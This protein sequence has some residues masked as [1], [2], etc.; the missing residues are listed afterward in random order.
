MINQHKIKNFWD[1]RAD[2]VKDLTFESIVNLEEDPKNLQ[3]KIDLET[4]K[5]FDWLPDL[6]GKTILDL[7]AGVGQWSFRFIERG[8]KHV[9][10]VEYSAPLAEIGRQVAIDRN[11]NNID[12]VVSGAEQFK[13]EEKFDVVFISGLFVYLVEDQARELMSNLPGFCH[14]DTFVL[15]RDGTAIDQHYEIND[16]HSAHLNTAYS[17]IYR[18]RE[19][20]ISLFAAAGLTIGRD[21][22]MFDEGCVLNKYKETRLRLYT[23]AYNA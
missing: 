2:K 21:E 15:L 17:A 11:I 10:A 16:R 8:A 19:E 7:G 9:T 20:Y 23:F 6:T 1:A 5:V 18:T 4:E 12:F 14:R 22:N 3:L 13:S